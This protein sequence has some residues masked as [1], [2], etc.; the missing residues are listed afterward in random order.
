M[1]QNRY[2][3]VLRLTTTHAYYGDQAGSVFSIT[4]MVNTAAEIARAGLVARQT[5]DGLDIFA[6]ER[7]YDDGKL[8]VQSL[9]EIV[10]SPE[11][12][13]ATDPDW[14]GELERGGRGN[15]NQWLR[16]IS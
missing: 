16:W 12:D 10:L 11:F 6:D 2:H 7:G 9:F 8:T 5:S 1:N 3:H 13:Q 14:C 15:S 4:P